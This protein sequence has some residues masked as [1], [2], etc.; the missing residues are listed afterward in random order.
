MIL[1][2]HL[3]Y[4]RIDRNPLLNFNNLKLLRFCQ[5]PL[6]I[7]LEVLLLVN[8]IYVQKICL[9]TRLACS[10]CVTC[11]FA[12]TFWRKPFLIQV[13][14]LNYF[15]LT[16]QAVLVVFVETSLRSVRTATTS[17]HYSPVRPSR[18]ASNRFFENFYSQNA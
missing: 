8:L 1:T 11:I 16:S 10:F 3:K 15:I 6:Q 2:H 4:S 13:T 12:N 5:I 17:L 7:V 14:N 18:L 9:Q